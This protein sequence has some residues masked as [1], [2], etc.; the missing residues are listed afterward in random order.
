M[1][2]SQPLGM[3]TIEPML[4][5]LSVYHPVRPA[6]AGCSAGT[7]VC[8]TINPWCTVRGPGCGVKRRTNNLCAEVVSWTDL[9]AK[10]G[11]ALQQRL[12]L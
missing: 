2:L 3:Q 6:D 8:S 10:R 4:A 12:G 5:E 9:M 1:T 7:D 11:N